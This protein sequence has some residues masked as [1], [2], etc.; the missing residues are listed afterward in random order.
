MQWKAAGHNAGS[1]DT[2]NEVMIKAI[3]A[4]NFTAVELAT[5]IT[6]YG[7]DKLI[8]YIDDQLED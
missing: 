1:D 4:H 7:A 2:P 3:K 8:S 5:L 6:K